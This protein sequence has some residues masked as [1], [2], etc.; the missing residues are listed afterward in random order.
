MEF[1]KR[2]A[3]ARDEF[4]E[5]LWMGDEDIESFERDY[6]RQLLDEE[7]LW[8]EFEQMLAEEDIE[9]T[10]YYCAEMEDDEQGEEFTAGK[11]GRLFWSSLN[12]A[13]PSFIPSHESSAVLTA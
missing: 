10:V 9:E 1:E 7:V 6:E 13:A 2:T 4:S 8:L 5:F 11:S 3:A 12:P